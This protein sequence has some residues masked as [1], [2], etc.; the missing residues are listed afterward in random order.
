MARCEPKTNL[1]APCQSEADCGHLAPLSVCAGGE[2]VECTAEGEPA[3]CGANT[4][5]PA[6]RRCTALP[7][8]SAGLCQRCVASRQCMEGQR[9]AAMLFMGE[10][11]PGGELHCLWEEASPLGPMGD[12]FMVRPYVRAEELETAEGDRARLCSLRVTT[13]EALNDY[14]MQ[15]C[16]DGTPPGETDEEC[17]AD[18]LDDGLCRFSAALG[19]LCTVPCLSDA[20]CLPGATCDIAATPRY[21]D[22]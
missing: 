10:P 6:A 20:D 22:L 8:R 9:C 4:C 2:C 1:C 18:G 14:S 21:C 19:N 7:E 11:L 17:G 15:S 12:C 5:D 16:T 3:A 13:C